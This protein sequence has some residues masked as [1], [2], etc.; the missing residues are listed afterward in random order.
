[1]SNEAEVIFDRLEG[2]LI[3]Q[4]DDLQSVPDFDDQLKSFRAKLTVLVGF[5]EFFRLESYK[6][7]LIH[8]MQILE[9]SEKRKRRR[10]TRKRDEA[11]K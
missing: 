7:D 3:K 6:K 9:E 5:F 11:N 8:I 10:R 4:V 2:L 1:M